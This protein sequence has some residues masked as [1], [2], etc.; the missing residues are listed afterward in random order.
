M[1]KAFYFHE[2]EQRK[3][4]F[5]WEQWQLSKL[6]A[7]EEYRKRNKR[8]IEGYAGPIQQCID[9]ELKGNFEKGQSKAEKQIETFLKT[10]NPTAV[11]PVDTSEKQK[12]REEIARETGR[13]PIVPPEDKFF[14]VNEKKLDALQEMVTNDIGKA[15][16]AVL[17]KMDD[18]YRQTI[19]KAEMYFTGGIKTVN[20][21]VDMA[22]KDFLEKGID[23]VEYKNGHKVNIAS[24]AEMALR[25]ASQRVT[26]LGEGKKRDEWGVYT[27]V[28]S[29]HANTC[30]L[31]LPWQGKVLIDDVFSH[32][33]KE[34]LE[35]NKEYKLV[36]EAMESGLLHPNCRHTLTTFF[37]GITSLPKIPDEDEALDSYEAEQKQ[38]YIERQIRKWKRM[39]AGTCDPEN[40]ALADGKLKELENKLKEHL[41]KNKQLRRDR[42]REQADIR[43]A[44]K[45]NYKSDLKQYEKI[46]KV[47]GKES[48]KTLKAFQELKYNN[49]E[50]W[51]NLKSD[52]RYKNM[53]NKR[54]KV[55]IDNENNSLPLKDKNNTIS[56][57]VEKSGNVKQRR[58][59]GED[60]KAI[61]DIDTSDHKK[62]KYHPMGAHKH[63]Y[64]YKNKNPHGKADYFTNEELRQNSDIIKKGD[65]Y[66]DDRHK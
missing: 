62:P 55:V 58:L 53:L 9:E 35:S 32:P 12:V 44:K 42:L 52:C 65:N 7:M 45:I 29:A 60:G 26:F 48:P 38:R 51:K 23:C 15:S 25:T 31:C 54:K 1:K 8:I 20:Q 50:E 14:G 64:D 59:Y 24:Y 40:E 63:E 57:L 2:R 10:K 18:V 66:N 56:D 27:V 16:N 6:R 39:K 37:P 33:P 11:L 5:S 28:V 22:T 34:Y 49:S 47:L 30:K 21:A 13:E 43:E 61:K 19:F 17:R 46:K 41:S 36:S 3:E 4:G